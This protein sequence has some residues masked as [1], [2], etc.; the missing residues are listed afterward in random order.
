METLREYGA[1]Y[2]R[3]RSNDGKSPVGSSNGLRG[4][5]PVQPA[6][7]FVWSSA[8]MVTQSHS[9]SLRREQ[10]SK[11][12]EEFHELKINV[13][14]YFSGRKAALQHMLKTG[15]YSQHDVDLMKNHLNVISKVSDIWTLGE[16]CYTEEN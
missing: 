10:P 1:R 14:I 12:S 11:V 8:L 16:R 15:L 4:T 6:G 13:S 9:S 5:L 2:P 3:E 7:R